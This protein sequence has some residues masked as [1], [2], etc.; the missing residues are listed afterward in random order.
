MTDRGYNPIKSW[1]AA[2]KL[3]L[4]HNKDIKNRLFLNS[5]KKLHF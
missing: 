3:V 2:K 5:K 1:T 4:F